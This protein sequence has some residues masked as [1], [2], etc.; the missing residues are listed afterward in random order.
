MPRGF[1]GEAEDL[2]VILADE[3]PG[4][5]TELLNLAARLGSNG[6]VVGNLAW[7][8]S[9]FGS[10]SGVRRLLFEEEGTSGDCSTG[11]VTKVRVKGA[12]KTIY[13]CKTT[14]TLYDGA[15]DVVRVVSTRPPKC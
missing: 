7:W 9:L 11:C 13:V 5:A 14:G 8:W 6:A 12:D 1:T 2:A 4:C 3:E 10:D 15:I